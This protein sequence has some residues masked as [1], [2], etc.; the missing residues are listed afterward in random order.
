MTRNEA[1]A[2]KQILIRECEINQLVVCRKGRWKSHLVT[3]K[4]FNAFAI[5]VT[6]NRAGWDGWSQYTISAWIPFDSPWN[7]LIRIDNFVGT[8]DEHFQECMMAAVSMNQ[9][10]PHTVR[11]LILLDDFPE[12]LAQMV[13]T[14]RESDAG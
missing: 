12:C 2:V 11:K 7:K 1:M 9:N 6:A 5:F 4:K 3:N 14:H 13:R 10:P 8:T